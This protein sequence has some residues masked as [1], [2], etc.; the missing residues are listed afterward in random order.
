[1]HITRS[2]ERVA[3]P[4]TDAVGGKAQPVPRE[5]VASSA[6]FLLSGAAFTQRPA[7]VSR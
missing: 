7:N 2:G 1:V 3:P 6:P 5:G 4:R